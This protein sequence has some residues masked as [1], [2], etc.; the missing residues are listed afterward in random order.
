MQRS[1]G[2]PAWLLL[3]W[4]PHTAHLNMTGSWP[5]SAICA[6]RQ[7]RLSVFTLMPST[8]TWGGIGEGSTMRVDT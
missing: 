8:S 5:T 6:R 2:A 4:Q 7:R 1:R 3:S